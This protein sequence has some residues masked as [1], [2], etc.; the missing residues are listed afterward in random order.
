MM[1]YET[2][3]AHDK[4]PQEPSCW[5][6]ESVLYVA[7]L[8]MMVSCFVLRTQGL[9]DVDEGNTIVQIVISEILVPIRRLT[10]ISV[11]LV[12]FLPVSRS[13]HFL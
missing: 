13:T 6:S 1:K 3:L 11:L 10:G 12:T 2:S 4:S 8:L 9:N 5:E 7:G